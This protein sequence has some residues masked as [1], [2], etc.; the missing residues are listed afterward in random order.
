MSLD[1]CLPADLRGPDTT[2][3]RITAGFSGAGVHRVDVSDRAFVL[4]VAAD[5]QPAATWRRVVEVQRLAAEAGLAPRVVH[6]DEERRAVV[7]EFLV[8]RSFMARC[9]NPATREAALSLL[10]RTI[11]RVHALPI[12]P[13][14]VPADGR[15]MLR[16]RW[17]TL[18]AAHSA[19]AFVGDAVRRFLATEVPAPDRATVLSHNDVNPTNVLHDG[20]RLLLLDWDAAAPNDPYYDLAVLPLFLRLD[21]EA[22]SWLIA[23]YDDAPPAALPARFLHDRWLI[24]LLLGVSFMSLD[25]EGA[26]ATDETLESATSL[27]DCYVGMRTGALDLR[28]AEGR[29]TYGLALV[30]EAVGYA[31]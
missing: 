5:D 20:E 28:T 31:R 1:E 23:A 16:E 2:I 6:V 25:R 26:R 12:P 3:S 30:K 7:S 17:S 27:A 14:A 29:R 22:C 18:E 9:Q 21:D 15:A 8:D 10:G 11:R 19:P 24:A 13:D 4:K